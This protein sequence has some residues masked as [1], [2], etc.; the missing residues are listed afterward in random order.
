MKKHLL[1]LLIILLP[2]GIFSQTSSSLKY[3]GEI[4][5][6]NLKSVLVTLASKEFEGR[7]T[8]EK[9]GEMAQDYITGLLK[10]NQIPSPKSI[11][12]LQN[13]EVKRGYSM[14]KEFL[15]KGKN[16]SKEY[17]YSNNY[18]Q[19]TILTVDQ[20]V[21][22]GYG[23]HDSLYNDFE[24]IDIS[25]KAVLLLAEGAPTNKYGVRYDTS[26]KKIPDREYMKSKNVKALFLIERNNNNM[27]YHFFRWPWVFWSKEKETT[28]TLPEVTISEELANRI[29]DSSDKTVKQ[30]YFEIERDGKSFPFIIHDKVSLKGDLSYE[31]LNA[32]NIIAFIEGSDLKNEFIVLSA[33][34]DHLGMNGKDIFY[35]ANDNA[36]GVS[37]AME[38]A[39]I[40]KKAQKEKKGPRRSVIILLTTAEEKGLHGARYYVENPVF[41]LAQT[42][43]CINLDMLGRINDEYMNSDSTYVYLSFE[44]TQSQPIVC[45]AEEAG[46]DVGKFNI[47]QDSYRE[48]KGHFEFS[49][50]Y[51]FHEKGIPSIMLS[52]GMFPEFHKPTDTADKIDYKSLY[53]RT[54]FAFLLLWKYANP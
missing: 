8:G 30:L 45:L 44:K 50:H 27:P 38:I 21:F 41:P 1:L 46:M 28:T 29:L 11:D 47:V 32:N 23:V 54:K 42:V 52:N 3:A 37:A 19:E 7:D 15:Y 17:H 25:N 33:H 14:E 35:G 12:Y 13:I 31:P 10:E 6:L 48:Q 40:L 39:R 22:A 16:Y 5:S 9:G 49:D 53:D 43:G 2:A 18:D 4:D 51:V 26:V 34:Y 24:N 36:S 20:L